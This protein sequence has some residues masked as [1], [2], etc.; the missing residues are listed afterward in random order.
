MQKIIVKFVL[1]LLMLTVTT[2]Q[3]ARFK[4]CARRRRLKPFVPRSHNEASNSQDAA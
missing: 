2:R 3:G 4:T 1:P